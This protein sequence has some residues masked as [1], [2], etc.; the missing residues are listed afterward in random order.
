MDREQQDG[1]RQG[2]RRSR[3]HAAG[4]RRP[5]RSTAL[6]GALVVAAGLTTATVGT[7]AAADA[8]GDALYAALLVLVVRFLLPAR[9]VVVHAAVAL[10]VCT[11][12]ELAQLTPAPAAAVRAVP[13]LRYVLGTTFVAT[14]LLAYGLGALLAG[15]AIAVSSRAVG[16]RPR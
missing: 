12:V 2:R 8:L 14:D 4:A 9:P 1:R 7:G 5:W 16:R 3:E 10:V 15:A 6:A 11:A 13:P